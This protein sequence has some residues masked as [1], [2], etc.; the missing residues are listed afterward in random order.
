MRSYGRACHLCSQIKIKV[1]TKRSINLWQ[2]NLEACQCGQISLKIYTEGPGPN[3][4]PT[5][6]TGWPAACQSESTEQELDLRT[7]PRL[8]SFIK[9]YQDDVIELHLSLLFAVA[10]LTAKGSSMKS[11][12]GKFLILYFYE[13]VKLIRL[14]QTLNK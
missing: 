12:E 4:M 6:G 3:G 1:G 11:R 14:L 13:S 8:Q 5:D 7:M 2:N 10:N 9:H